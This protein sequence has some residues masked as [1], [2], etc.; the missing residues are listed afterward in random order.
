MAFVNA[1]LS[2]VFLKL[3]LKR[4]IVSSF[5]MPFV[6][7]ADV[8]ATIINNNNKYMILYIVCGLIINSVICY[9]D[10]QI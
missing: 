9:S 4:F 7:C 6:S 1:T 5:N 3:S 10:C 8:L 2:G